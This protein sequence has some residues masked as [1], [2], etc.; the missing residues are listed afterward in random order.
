M[1]RHVPESGGLHQTL[2]DD[3]VSDC[4]YGLSGLKFQVGNSE[5]APGALRVTHTS[6]CH[7]DSTR[8]SATVARCSIASSG[9]KGELADR[10]RPKGDRLRRICSRLGL[11][12]GFGLCAS[13][14]SLSGGAARTGEWLR[15]KGDILRKAF[16]SGLLARF[17][18]GICGALFSFDTSGRV[19]PGVAACAGEWL[20]PTGDKLRP[21]LK[22]DRLRKFCIALSLRCALGLC[23]VLSPLSGRLYASGVASR[24]GERPRLK[25]DRLRKIW[26]G[27]LEP[28]AF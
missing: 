22:G 19:A 3:A 17:E 26:S 2:A 28:F 18:F 11:R 16:C 7:R 12:C 9:V 6:G 5:A 1:I 20:Q 25:G 8:A 21:R 14:S 13:P 4:L 27:L 24:A 23:D 15:P 10:P